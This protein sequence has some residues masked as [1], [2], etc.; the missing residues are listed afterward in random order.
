MTTIV[1]LRR[2]EKFF[3]SVPAVTAFDLSIEE[4][5]FVTLLGPSGCGKTTTL[6]MVAGLV[7]VTSGDILVKGRRINDVPIHRRN[8]GLVFQ[9][10]ALF[11]HK[12]VFDNVAYGLKFRSLDRAERERRVRRALDIV[13]LPQFIDRFPGQLSGGQQ[14]RVA[15]ARAIVIEPDV[16]LLDE[17][18][19]ALDAGLREE[20]RVELKTIQRSLGITTIF[21]THDQAEA[22]ALSDKIVVM[23]HGTKEQEGPPQEVYDRPR[24][25]FVADFLGHSNFL[26][27]MLDEAAGGLARLRLPQGLSLMV[28]APAERAPGPATVVL[29]AEKLQLHRV[30]DDNKDE[31]GDSTFDAVVTTLDYQGTTVRYFL[32]AGGLRLQ[33]IGMIDGRPIP[34]GTKV[35]VSIRPADCVLLPS[36]A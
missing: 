33:A 19:S 20:M 32:E 18:L 12:N 11:P 22:L 26:E 30:H 36:G 14:Q 29:R 9:N 2:V 16:L 24:T 3:G 28:P 15:L 1:E 23:N 13:R 21:V 6:R 4:G 34:E 10:F 27:G 8:L 35:E 5:T 7:D 17:P 31:R 25:R